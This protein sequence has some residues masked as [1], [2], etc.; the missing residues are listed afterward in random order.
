MPPITLDQALAYGRQHS[1]RLAAAKQGVAT[2]QTAIA[3]AT[4]E[5]LPHLGLGAAVRGANQPTET[6]LTL[7]STPLADVLGN[8]AFRRGHLNAEVVATLPVYTGGRIRSAQKLAEAERDLA[9]VRVHDVE[10]QLDVDVTT[11]YASLVQ[12]DR[13]IEAAQESVTALAEGRRV[14]AQ[15][16]DEGKVARVDLLKVDTRVA[17][18]EDTAIEFR[19]ARE[20]QVGQFNALLGCPIDTPVVVTTTLPKRPIELS[21]SQVELFASARNT[22]YQLAQAQVSIA[23]RST[24]VV[25]SELRPSLS[26]VTNLFGQSADPFSIYRSGVVAG[27]VL[28]FPF[29]TGP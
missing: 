19:N 4:A 12:L 10:Q 8:Q 9:Q 6:A 11:V 28:S 17:E 14:V 23:E 18:V 22:K 24:R 20:I 3:V 2:E 26:L 13:D 16:L 25:K 15:M 29:S 1:P 7:P 5:R 27:A 21:P